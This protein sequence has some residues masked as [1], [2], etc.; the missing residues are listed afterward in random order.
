MALICLGVECVDIQQ[1]AQQRVF[2]WNTHKCCD[3]CYL[4]AALG[5][6]AYLEVVVIEFN[7]YIVIV[8]YLWHS[9]LSALGADVLS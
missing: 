7:Y 1:F 8:Y 9:N 6:S 2:N 5:E 4:F 3:F